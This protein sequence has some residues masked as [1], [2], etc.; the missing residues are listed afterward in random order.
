MISQGQ[1]MK[2][3]LKLTPQQLLLMRLLQVPAAV[4]EQTIKQEIERNP[5]LEDEHVANE[6]DE[7]FE[8]EADNEDDN[9]D[10]DFDEREIDP[11]EET[12]ED[13]DNDDYRYRERLE[14]DKNTEDRETPISSEISF[15]EYLIKQ[16]NLKKITDR[17]ALI[18]YEIIGSIDDTG[19]LSRSTILLANDMAFKQGIDTTPEEVEAVLHIV[20]TLDPVGVGARNLQE[21]LSLQLHRMDGRDECVRLATIIVDNHFESFAKRHYPVIMNR[22]GIDSDQLDKAIDCIKRLN[23]KPGSA[24]SGG[25]SRDVHYIIPDFVV[26]NDENFGL[27]FTINDNNLPELHVSRHYT[28]LLQQLMGSSNP[29]KGDRDTIR[30]IKEKAENARCFIEMLNQRHVTLHK[31]MDCILGCQQQFFTTGNTTDLRPMKLKDI[32]DKTG[33][34]ISTISRVVNQKYV[35]TEFGTFLLKELFTKGLTTNE[36][37]SVSTDAIKHYLQEAV[38]NEDKQH[39]L[40][41]DALTKLLNDKGYPLARRTV[42]KYRE[43]MGIPVGRLRKELKK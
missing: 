6:E 34:D 29:S 5:L 33:F 17:E 36:G 22:M 9:G 43:T 38:N 2:L 27:S 15:A 13:Y 10:T 26:T 39:P 1:K 35:Q 23:P 19:Y 18:G 21:C 11:F 3:H 42:A 25:D 4:L 40:T 28:D 12:D 14:H 16:L 41:D 37:E 32:S 20:Q 8:D 7:P 31:I 24:Y 30:F